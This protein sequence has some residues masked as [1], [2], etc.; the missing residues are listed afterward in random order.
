MSERIQEGKEGPPWTIVRRYSSFAEAAQKRSELLAD[1]EL[2]VK[3]R[4]MPG[5]WPQS[6]KCFAVKTRLDP[7]IEETRLILE[8]R[9][10]KK[11]RKKKLQKKRRKK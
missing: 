7:A 5:V 11:R 3:V 1:P 6:D 2:Q 10:F 8:H 4:F 9:E